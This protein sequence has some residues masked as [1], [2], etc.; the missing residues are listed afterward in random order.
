MLFPETWCFPYEQA[1]AYFREQVD[2]EECGPGRFRFGECNIEVTALPDEVIDNLVLPRT[3]VVF[4]GSGP[5][6]KSIRHRFVSRFI[7]PFN[8]TRAPF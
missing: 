2:V 8:S 7:S 5:D 3:K 4:L 6:M 1:E